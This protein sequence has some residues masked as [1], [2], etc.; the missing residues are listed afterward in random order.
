[1]VPSD[2]QEVYI[3]PTKSVIHMTYKK[4]ISDLQ[5]VYIQPKKKCT[6]DLQKVY[7]RPKTS[8]LQKEGISLPSKST[9]APCSTW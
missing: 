7:I 3:Q 2:L 1:M 6:S 4:C 5:K 8:D 9:Q